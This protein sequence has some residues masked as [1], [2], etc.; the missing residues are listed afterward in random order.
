[1]TQERRTQLML[2]S[3]FS[4]F[5]NVLYIEQEDGSKSS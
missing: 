5:I 3:N 2:L 1:M 4:K